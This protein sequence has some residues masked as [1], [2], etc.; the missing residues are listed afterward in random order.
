M[1]SA[2]TAKAT[3]LESGGEGADRQRDVDDKMLAEVADAAAEEAEII[4][5]VR[6]SASYKRELLRVYAARAVR[7]R[8]ASGA[9]H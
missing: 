6:G 2:A 3:R 8:H 9:Q 4:A 1:V 5:D 7:A